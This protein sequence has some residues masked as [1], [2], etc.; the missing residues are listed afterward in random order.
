MVTVHFYCLIPRTH[1]YLST[2][3]HHY[4]Y[5]YYYYYNEAF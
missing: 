1:T 5:Y 4:Y 2:N 3:H